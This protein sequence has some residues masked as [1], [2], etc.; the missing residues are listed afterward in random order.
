[1]IEKINLVISIGT[2]FIVFI[3]AGRVNSF[4]K[5]FEEGELH[6]TLA[7]IQ[8]RLTKARKRKLIW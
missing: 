7:G 5:W 1:M 3:M 4:T 8:Q 2:L 6:R